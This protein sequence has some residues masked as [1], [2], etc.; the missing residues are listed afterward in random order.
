MSRTLLKVTSIIQSNIQYPQHCCIFQALFNIPNYHPKPEHYPVDQALSIIQLSSI[1]G[2]IHPMS[3]TLLKV[4]SIIQSNIQYSQHCCIFQALFNIPNYH[5]K[6]EH[7]PVYQVLSIIHLSSIKGIIYYPKQHPISTALSPVPSIIQY[8]KL[9]SKTRALSS[10]PSIIHYPTIQNLRSYPSNIQN[11]MKVLSILQSNIQ[12]PQHCPLFQSITQYPKLSS[13][14]GTLSSIPNI[15]HYLTI[16]HPRYYPSI[17]KSLFK[18]LSI[19]PSNIQYPQRCPL[20]QA[21]FNIPNNHPKI[22][23]IIQFSTHYPVSKAIS[24]IQSNIYPHPYPAPSSIQN[25]TQY[26]RLYPISKP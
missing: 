2:I 18:A 24:N 7:Y 17:I 13:K 8:P 20:F 3:S 10:I 25:I 14:T 16:Q 9:S 26:P 21:L 12:Y 15:V 4:L 19:I 1:Q 5:P 11:P 23:S 6:P 22:R